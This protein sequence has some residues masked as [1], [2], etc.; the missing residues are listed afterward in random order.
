MT[1]VHVIG[2]G[3]DGVGGLGEHVKQI[4]IK[5]NLLVGSSRHLT[6][7]PNHSAQR[8]YITDFQQAIAGI[9]QHLDNGVK[10]IVVLVSGDPLFFGAGRLL[11]A[12]IPSEKISFYPHVSSVQLAFNRIKLPWQDARIISVHGRSN[13]ELIKA[14][15]QG[16]EKIAVL[17][18]EKNNPKTIFNLVHSLNLT[19][20]YKLWV[21]EN[22]GG[23]DERIL[24]ILDITSLQ[25]DLQNNEYASLNVVIL[26]RQDENKKI[27]LETLPFL[28]IPDDY[29]LSFTDRPGLMTKREVRVMVLGELGLRPGQI[30]WDIGAGTGSV[31]I[32]IARLFPTSKIYAVEKTAAGINLIK[33]NSERF[34][35][36]NITAISGL[37]P[38]NLSDLPK[39]DRV[40]IGG[41]GGNLTSI[42]D[43]CAEN[44]HTDG[45]I[46]LALATLEHLNT[47]LSWLNSHDWK[48][49]L[50]QVQLS[51]SVP[52]GI[53]TRFAPLN[54]VT[55]VSIW[56][57]S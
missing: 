1:K 5:A 15:Q 26:L 10:G 41:S 25:K 6:Y 11:L 52:V 53:L 17:T 18:D 51:R 28:G 39:C 29:F 13:Q 50:L 23:K 35:V 4:I 30:L 19:N 22:L 2:I 38:S 16:V 32:E 31:S 12:E 33:A 48:Y 34:Q 7:F 54:P 9:R 47:V 43:I 45:K 20:Q 21:C 57:V 36:E 49:Q 40:F 27:N 14:L 46:V 42:L 24:E 3:L 8:L 56:C 37:A 44:L 55:I